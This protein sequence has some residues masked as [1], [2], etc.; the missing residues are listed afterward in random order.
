MSENMKL[1]KILHF[2]T[3]LVFAAISSPSQGAVLPRLERGESLTICAIG[4]SLTGD[5][6][7]PESKSSKR[8]AWFPLMGQWLNTLYPHKVT[9]FNEGIGSAASKYTAT[10]KS[11]GSGLDV[12]LR[13]ALAH[14]PDVIFIEFAINDAYEPYRISRQMSKDNL[15]AMIDQ[16]DAWAISHHKTVDIVIQTMNNTTERHP[17]PDQANYYQ[18]YRD[19]AA[20]NKLLLIDHYPNWVALYNSEKNHAK[21]NRYVNAGV[22]P[23]ELGAKYIILPEIQRA[24]KKQTI[25]KRMDKVSPPAH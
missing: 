1:C 6:Y 11:P 9:L 19:V 3:F 18:G 22:H 25:P 16:I 2:V 20:A 14:T 24:L 10:Y 23:N 12:Q 7:D 8:S 13:R 5:Y 15:Q 4:T 21:W 17:A